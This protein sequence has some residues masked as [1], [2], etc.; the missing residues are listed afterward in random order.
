VGTLFNDAIL[1][2][3]GDEASSVT[4]VY[5]VMSLLKSKLQNRRD[6]AYFGDACMAMMEQ[7]EEL[8]ASHQTTL[9]KTEFTAF[10][11]TAISYLN[12]W[13]D[14]SE[15][16]FLH[17]AAGLSLKSEFPSFNQ[18]KKLCLLPYLKEH[19]VKDRL[20]DEYSVLK[21]IWSAKKED[22]IAQVDTPE[23]KWMTLLGQG[24]FP[25]M[26]LIVGFVLSVPASNAPA[27]RVFSKMTLKCSKTRN[28]TSNQLLKAEL[29]ISS[30]YTMTCAEFYKYAVT[31]K[32]LC[33]AAGTSSKYTS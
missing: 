10:Y 19:V 1:S 3:E 20:F 16:S 17:Q 14:Y 12:K 15:E 9:F 5:D 6:E 28:A 33:K 26:T 4:E 21:D 30:N 8:D 32:D 11:D 18:L 22:I 2:I 23:K 29:Q 7:L 13:F 24:N 31:N 27:E 25:N